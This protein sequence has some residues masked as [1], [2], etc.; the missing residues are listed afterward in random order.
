MT[1]NKF[2]WVRLP[3]LRIRLAF[4]TRIMKMDIHPTAQLSL[5]AKLDKTFPKGVHIGEWSYLA[6]DVRVLTHDRTRGL[7]AHTRVG[8]NCFIGGGAIILPGVNIGDGSV[9]GAGSVVSKDV[10][11]G[12]VVAGNPAR[13]IRSDISVGPY[14][15]FADADECERH[16]RS[17]DPA[18]AALPDTEFRKRNPNAAGSNRRG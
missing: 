10:P 16:L 14:G 17:T 9:V 2:Y 4:L 3:L 13:V 1:L 6:F 7:Y 12:C 15:R 18:V 11:A 8:K 5:S